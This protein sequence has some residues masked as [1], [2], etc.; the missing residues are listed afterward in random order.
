MRGRGTVFSAGALGGGGGG[1]G[2]VGSAVAAVGRG[3]ALVCASGR[4]TSTSRTH[5]APQQ[6]MKRHLLFC[7][8]WRIFTAQTVTLPRM[9]AM[10]RAISREAML[11]WDWREKLELAGDCLAHTEDGSLVLADLPYGTVDFANQNWSAAGAA[12]NHVRVVVVVRGG[13]IPWP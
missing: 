12:S 1:R 7:T 11:V 8:W 9:P 3:G 10:A 4:S 2:D 6:L 13:C 5:S